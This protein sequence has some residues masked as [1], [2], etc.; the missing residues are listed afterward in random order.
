MT[1]KRIS[2]RLA[3]KWKEPYSRICGCV[4]SWVEITLVRS[5]HSCIR[6]GRGSGVLHQYDPSA[7]GRQCGLPSLTIRKWARPVLFNL[8]LHLPPYFLSPS[9]GVTPKGKAQGT[10]PATHHGK[11]TYHWGWYPSTY[12]HTPRTYIDNKSPNLTPLF[13]CL[14][15]CLK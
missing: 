8:P 13:V 7:V 2:I 15:V 1:L 4:N 14:F 9:D 10:S 12:T 11:V 6:G 3:Q 5:I